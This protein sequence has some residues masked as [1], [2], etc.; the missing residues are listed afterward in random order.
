MKELNAMIEIN[1]L[2]LDIDTI[3]YEVVRDYRV[4]GHPTDNKLMREVCV[5]VGSKISRLKSSLALVAHEANRNHV[6]GKSHET[7]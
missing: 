1:R 5:S 4:S 2:L 7:T 6:T 3:L